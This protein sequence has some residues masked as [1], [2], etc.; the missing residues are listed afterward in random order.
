MDEK[1]IKK[2]GIVAVAVP[3]LTVGTVALVSAYQSDNNFQPF[4]TE[5]EL[6]KNQV[7]FS[8]DEDAVGQQEKKQGDESEY[9]KKDETSN[10]DKSPTP[11]SQDGK[12]LFENGILEQNDQAQNTAGILSDNTASAIQNATGQTADAAGQPLY[13]LTDDRSQANTILH[14]N[15]NQQTSGVNNGNGEEKDGSSGIENTGKEEKNDKED[16]SKKEDNK[17]SSNGKG[18]SGNGSE[19]NKDPLIPTPTPTPIQKPSYQETAVDSTIKKTPQTMMDGSNK[20]KEDNAASSEN[21]EEVPKIQILPNENNAIYKGQSIDRERVF[22]ALDIYLIKEKEIYFWA[23]D[24]LDRYVKIDGV[25]FDGGETWE[26][27]FPL[28]TPTDTASGEMKIKLQYRFFEKSTTWTQMEVSYALEDSRVYVLSEELKEN[29]QVLDTDKVLNSNQFLDDGSRLNLLQYQSA[30]MGYDQLTTLFPGWYENGKPVKW[31]YPVTIGRHILEPAAPVA[32]DPAYTVYL[33]QLWM[34][35][36]F[37]VGFQYD[38]LCYLQ[39]LTNVDESVLQEDSRGREVLQVPEYIQAVMLDDDA[40]ISVDY[41][42]IPDTVLYIAGNNNGLKVNKGYLVG[43][44]NPCYAMADHG[45][46]TNKA[47]TEY[48]NIPYEKESVIVQ[49]GVTK[50]NIST[51]NA[52]TKVQLEAD[53]MDEMPELSY[54]NLENCNILVKDELLEDFVKENWNT[55][56]KNS[57]N[58]VSSTSDSSRTYRLKYGCLIDQAGSVRRLLEAAGSKVQLAAE[59]T[60]IEE[61]AFDGFDH[62]TTLVMPKSGENITLEENC[63]KNCGL[64]KIM[65]YTELQYHTIIEQLIGSGVG[66]DVE[67]ELLEK[68]KE[69]YTYSRQEQDGKEEVSLVSVPDDLVYFDGTMTDKEGNPVILTAIDEYAFGEAEQ[70]QWVE[71]PESIKKIGREAFWK[72]T[73]LQGVMIESTDSIEI[74]DQAFDECSSLRFVASNAMEGVMDDNYVP[75]I[76][77]TYGNS[78]FFVPTDSEG[79]NGSLSFVSESGVCSYQ[80]V[81]IGGCGKALYG[82]DE[83]GTP[84]ILLRSG[85]ELAPQTSLP[86]T[87]IEIWSQALEYTE[88][89]G[90]S[91]TVNWSDF[92]Q[93]FIDSGAFYTS[94]LSGD[95]VLGNS[96]Y[97]ASYAMYNCKNITSVTIGENI[98]QIGES[99]F[100][101]CSNLQKV[102]FG[103]MQST[104]ALYAGL[105]TNCDQLTS[106]TIEDYLGPQLIVFGNTAF[107]FNYSWSEE[108]EASRLH[109]EIPEGSE[110]NYIKRWR[111]FFAGYTASGDYPAYLNMWYDIRYE[112]MDML[113][114]EFP[115]DEEVDQ[116][117]AE[118]LLHVENRIRSMIGIEAVTEPSEYYPYHLNNEG[119]LTLV[120]APSD[121]TYMNLWMQLDN[122]PD[123]WYLD[124][125]GTGAF[126]RAKNLEMIVIPEEIT[127][128][129]SNAF[130]GVES[131]SLTMLFPGTT[132]PKLMEWSKEEPFVFGAAE[133]SIHIE[134]WGGDPQEYIR[135]WIFPMVGYT[136]LTEMRAGVK[137]ELAAEGVDDSD[138]AVDTEIAKRLLPVENRLRKMFGMEEIADVKDLSVELENLP[139]ETADPD[140]PEQEDPEIAGEAGEEQEQ[141]AA[142][143]GQEEDR[144]EEQ[145]KKTEDIEK[146]PKSDSKNEASDPTNTETDQKEPDNKESEESE[147]TNQDASAGNDPDTEEHTQEKGNQKDTDTATQTGSGEETQE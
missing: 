87:T 7:V 62:V 8:D 28:M 108:E 45:I 31:Y 112:N 144:Q 109:I 107:Q 37:E 33:R 127:G 97:L 5:R 59:V 130:E 111:Y 36:D 102:H 110:M 83:N 84:W 21:P 101:G 70:L 40:N 100:G 76:H 11:G 99:V 19:T 141:D 114:W 81:N 35:D 39:A 77:D 91:Y 79:Y 67:V 74:G 12:Y 140:E 136:D 42:E 63:F 146:N 73:S 94:Q 93:L 55:L 6:Q 72:C 68:S 14:T 22:N 60:N 43:E 58:T 145:E 90:G 13:N 125:I 104:V 128:I 105:F 2:A 52:I 29:N 65:C 113:T 133:E 4:A 32:L 50:V 122:L 88:A 38:N 131:G 61:G 85:S 147:Q 20:Y 143:S 117:V 44:N 34:S 9:W 69:G 30:Y 3:V 26:N 49:K 27:E 134:L 17:D 48:L 116:I 23:E 115:S 64:K 25:S 51:K 96:C 137:E 78:T 46:L 123:G 142:V 89:E 124:Y 86:D 71:L 80:I 41:I 121:T 139:D 75:Q 129:Y 126:K 103:T 132:P 82:N 120:G 118:E 10:Q 15:G 18:E 66:T 92:G 1:K 16:N 135:S 57:G 24:A 53:S 98:L 47:G 54:E 56:K 95:I 138:S 119:M 106:I